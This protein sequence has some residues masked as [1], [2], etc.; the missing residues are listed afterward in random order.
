MVLVAL[1]VFLVIRSVPLDH[2]YDA[3][4]RDGFDKYG[5]RIVAT[6]GE[7][8]VSDCGGLR[9]GLHQGRLRLPEWFG[10]RVFRNELLYFQK[11]TLLLL[12]RVTDGSEDDEHFGDVY[13]FLLRIVYFNLYAI[14]TYQSYCKKYEGKPGIS[15]C[16]QDDYVN[17]SQRVWKRTEFARLMKD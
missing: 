4:I 13:D 10:R 17:I 11:L 15:P 12:T 8:N 6:L 7:H 2:G 16:P 3:W 9:N 1:F 14:N 5:R